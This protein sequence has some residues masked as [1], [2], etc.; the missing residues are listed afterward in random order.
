MYEGRENL[1]GQSPVC[2]LRRFD[3]PDEE[4]LGELD[5]GARCH[6]S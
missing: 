5:E 4:T 3:L 1:A 2:T 6:L